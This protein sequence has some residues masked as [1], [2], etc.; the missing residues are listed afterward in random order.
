M[1]RVI[2]LEVKPSQ[3]DNT[4]SWPKTWPE[5]VEGAAKCIPGLTKTEVARIREEGGPARRLACGDVWFGN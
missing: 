3:S 1:D 4:P 5:G 2:R